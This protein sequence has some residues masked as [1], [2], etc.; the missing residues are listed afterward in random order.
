MSVVK[1]S[2]GPKGRDYPKYLGSKA[3][4]TPFILLLMGLML[5]ADWG[6]LAATRGG[7]LRNIGV[8]SVT[9]YSSMLRITLWAKYLSLIPKWS[10]LC[11]TREYFWLILVSNKISPSVTVYWAYST[12]FGLRYLLTRVYSPTAIMIMTKNIHFLCRVLFGA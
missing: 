5:T 12:F 1:E 8:S 3:I 6:S 11:L 2:L 9:D 4:S 10:T 7:R